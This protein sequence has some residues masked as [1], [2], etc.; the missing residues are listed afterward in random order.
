M[1]DLKELLQIAGE[2]K[3]QL[4]A[5][6][7]F[8]G[9][10]GRCVIGRVKRRRAVSATAMSGG[11]VVAVGALA[12]GGSNL[13]W[14]SFVLGA[15]PGN[16]P[17]AVCTTTTPS[18]LA[19][20]AK[21]AP[22]GA[23]RAFIDNTTGDVAFG[24]ELDG[25]PT[26]W[27][28]GQ[29]VS[30]SIDS[31]FP[32]SWTFPSGAGFEFFAPAGYHSSP[33]SDVSSLPISDYLRQIAGSPSPVP[34]VACVTTTP[35]PSAS[36][37]PLP[38]ATPSVHSSVSP[39]PT[40]TPTLPVATANSPFQC[41]YTLPTD[42]HWSSHLG[43]RIFSLQTATLHGGVWNRINEVLAETGG[44]SGT[45]PQFEAALTGD[46]AENATIDNTSVDDPSNGGHLY[47]LSFVAVRDGVVVGTVEPSAEG[48]TPRV[49]Y[50]K[51]PDSGTLFGFLMSND[52][53]G[54][55]ALTPCAGTATGLEGAELYGV[56]GYNMDTGFPGSYSWR[57][58]GL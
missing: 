49:I 52:P 38:S 28:N 21:D 13:P 7:D 8:A 10:Y 15:A 11:T 30:S 23:T 46:S 58:S 54:M 31:G 6:E 19:A 37:S 48:T 12:F 14:G 41:G 44:A 47:G 55:D 26:I 33:E 22:A 40:P 18:P 53:T 35:E 5:S 42:E 29:V 20:S 1:S 51:S 34:V 39:A 27:Y 36:T 50:Y 56:A 2:A 57:N 32:P 9:G 43:V 24:G 4:F 45:W 25:L 16:S 3:R 17:S